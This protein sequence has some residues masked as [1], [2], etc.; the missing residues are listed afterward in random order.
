EQRA[1]VDLGFHPVGRP[2]GLVGAELRRPPFRAEA[3]IGAAVFLVGHRILLLECAAYA[4][5][6]SSSCSSSQSWYSSR[7]SSITSVTT[8]K[9]FSST[10]SSW[11]STPV[12]SQIE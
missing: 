11:S 2:L 3:A 7:F 12:A 10:L 8:S 4:S 5:S 9:R 1:L 6:S